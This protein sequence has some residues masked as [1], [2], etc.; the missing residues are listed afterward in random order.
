MPTT[1]EK[2]FSMKYSKFIPA[3][4]GL[5]LATNTVTSLVFK[6]EKSINDI[7]YNDSK[8]GRKIDQG[9]DKVLLKVT[10]MFKD[11]EIL[12]LNRELKKCK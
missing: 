12:R 10:I 7:E 6:Q 8:S 11:E 5:L 9:D 4:V 1:D 3:I 2:V